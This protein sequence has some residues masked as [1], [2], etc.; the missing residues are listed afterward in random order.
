MPD[1][2][3]LLFILFVGNRQILKLGDFPNAP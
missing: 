1:F 3:T 2:K